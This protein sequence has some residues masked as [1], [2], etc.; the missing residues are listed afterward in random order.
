MTPEEQASARQEFLRLEQAVRPEERSKPWD[1]D[2]AAKSRFPVHEL[3]AVNGHC[4]RFK[5][6]ATLALNRA[7]TQ[8]FTLN[9]AHCLVQK[10]LGAGDGQT[11]TLLVALFSSGCILIAWLAPIQSK[12][13]AKERPVNGNL[14]ADNAH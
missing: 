2:K 11:L 13:K 8:T 5:Y 14:G 7:V 12:P 9:R 4:L 1:I 3:S 6:R 10:S